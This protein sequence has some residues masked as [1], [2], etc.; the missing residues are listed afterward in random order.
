MSSKMKVSG[1]SV[2]N[3]HR[4]L[5]LRKTPLARWQNEACYTHYSVVA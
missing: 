4:E 5:Y 2:F 1:T 3:S